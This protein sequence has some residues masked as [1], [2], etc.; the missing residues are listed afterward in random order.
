MS[1]F[2][3]SFII[4]T[5][6]FVM[7]LILCSKNQFRLKPNKTIG[8]CLFKL[9]QWEINMLAKGRTIK[10]QTPKSDEIKSTISSPCANNPTFCISSFT[11]L[12]IDVF[13]IQ[14]CTFQCTTATTI[15]KLMSTILKPKWKKKFLTHY[16]NIL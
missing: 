7:T 1:I 5:T 14:L 9:C 11:F 8:G 12:Y 6:T 10:A 13:K 4:C 3:V 16:N 15:L 2:N